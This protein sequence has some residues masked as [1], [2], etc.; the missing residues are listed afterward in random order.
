MD[1][2]VIKAPLAEGLGKG[3]KAL[4]WGAGVGRVNF[5]LIYG[6]KLQVAIQ[7]AMV[8]IRG[9]SSRAHG[10]KPGPH[11]SHLDV[12]GSGA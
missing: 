1:E 8:W 11:C 10:W 9:C 12:V 2:C 4:L 3:M 6:Y 5:L 7:L